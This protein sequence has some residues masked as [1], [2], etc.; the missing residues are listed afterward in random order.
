MTTDYPD[1]FASVTT[2]TREERECARRRFADNP[3][4]LW[5]AVTAALMCDLGETTLD[6]MQRVI[7]GVRR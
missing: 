7:E 1:A 4:A 2:L 3:D 5:P 6:L